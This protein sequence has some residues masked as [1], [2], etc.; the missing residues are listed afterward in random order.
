MVPD[1]MMGVIYR[2][3]Y[4]GNREDIFTFQKALYALLDVVKI[5]LCLYT[6]IIIFVR[7]PNKAVPIT[8][9]LNMSRMR[10]GMKWWERFA[11]RNRFLR[12]GLLAAVCAWSLSP[13]TIALF[14][15]LTTLFM[16]NVLGIRVSKYPSRLLPVILNTNC[17]PLSYDEVV[18]RQCMSGLVFA[19]NEEMVYG[20]TSSALIEKERRRYAETDG[21]KET[22][23]E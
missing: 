6:Q 9:Y 13:R 7:Q 20:D 5:R 23:T 8:E 19:T 21:H 17:S 4:I 14:P 22:I 16:A 3:Y 10:R 15:A 11:P 1:E 2:H 12:G 18:G